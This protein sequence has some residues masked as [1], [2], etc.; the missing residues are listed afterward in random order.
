MR[1]MGN[2]TKERY[3]LHPVDRGTSRYNLMTHTPPASLWYSWK[4]KSKPRKSRAWPDSLGAARDFKVI[5]QIP[6]V[7]TK[8]AWLGPEAE[9]GTE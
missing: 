7:L 4:A 8:R 1:S 6:G 2:K 9:V 3:K 5:Q